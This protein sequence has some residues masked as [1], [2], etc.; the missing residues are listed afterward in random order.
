MAQQQQKFWL[1][2]R[3][4]INKDNE[5]FNGIFGPKPERLVNG[6]YMGSTEFEWGAIPAAY[7]RIH[8]DYEEYGFFITPFKTTKG[9]PL[10]LFCKKK[11]YDDI[12][13]ELQRYNKERY[14]TKEYTHFYQ[15]FEF[16]PKDG[17]WAAK[18]HDYAIKSTDFWWCIDENSEEPG[19]GHHTVGDWM[20]FVAD[21]RIQEEFKRVLKEDY[22]E[23]CQKYPTEELRKAIRAKAHYPIYLSGLSLP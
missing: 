2:Q 10:C 11:Y 19:Y 13:A 1:I 15:H 12:I 23:F 3:G 21:E 17:G 9:L 16:R 8:A 6:D 20:A 22:E 14:Q 4:K 18:D 5:T 7:I